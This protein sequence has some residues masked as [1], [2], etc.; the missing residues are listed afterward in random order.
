V[1]MEQ[2]PSDRLDAVAMRELLD[3][4]CPPLDEP[5][6][7]ALV[8]P[9]A[10]RVFMDRHREL[11]R[12]RAELLAKHGWTMLELLTVEHDARHAGMSVPG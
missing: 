8:E 7:P 9:E 1:R 2:G 5:L 4:E 10:H 11:R 6:P 12:A 3:R